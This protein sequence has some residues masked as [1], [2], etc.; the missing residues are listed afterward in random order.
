MSLAKPCLLM[1]GGLLEVEK[2][3]NGIAEQSG[4]PLTA[5]RLIGGVR[6]PKAFC[7]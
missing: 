2:Q 6:L 7:C 1:A 4:Q 3:M 5:G